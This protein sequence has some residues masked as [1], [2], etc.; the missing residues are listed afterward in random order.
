[1]EC[2][3]RGLIDVP[4]L[5]FGSGEALLRAL[6]EIGSGEGIGPLLRLGSRGMAEEVGHG[7]IA[8]AAQVKGL[9]LPGYEPRTLQS[10]ALGLAVNARGADHNRSGAYEADFST[11]VDRLAGDGRS[12][13]AAIETED[14]AALIDSMI[15]C[16][17]LRGVFADSRA[18]W[19]ELLS[20]VTGFDYTAA[21][22]GSIAAEIVDEKKRYNV[23]QGWTPESDTLPERF[24]NEPL[25]TGG[26]SAA[27]LPRERLQ[28]MVARY[29][30]LRGWDE[31]GLPGP[32]LHD[33]AAQP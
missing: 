28:E 5:R 27:T 22:L 16:K 10:M 31:D 7:S 1:M 25:E 30:R 3:E 17:F 21:E 29:Y 11:R 8:F 12:V 14:N 9:E 32:D 15:L 26:G 4:W 20:A 33:P 13:A 23:E 18:E 6:D 19:A 24:L 2:V